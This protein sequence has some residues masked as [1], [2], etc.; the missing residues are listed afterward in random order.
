MNRIEIR[1]T[2]HPNMSIFRVTFE[3]VFAKREERRIGQAIVLEDNDARRL[4]KNPI[5]PFGN[6]TSQTDV[7]F[8]K[9][10]EDFAWP[11]NT[12][13]NCACRC[14]SLAIRF[15]FGS[16]TIRYYEKVPR[17][18]CANCGKN[19]RRLLRPIENNEG[20]RSAEC[21]SHRRV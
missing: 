6:V 4:I 17:P 1:A 3:Q 21:T 16:R 19:F 5:E 10:P 7:G 20:N 2:D 14:A 12:F 8:G 9:S 13:D 15:Y 18:R 11:I